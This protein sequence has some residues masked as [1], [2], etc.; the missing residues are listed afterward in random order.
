MPET[1]AAIIFRGG[2][3]RV[4]RINPKLKESNLPS[5]A[6]AREGNLSGCKHESALMG[7]RGRREGLRARARRGGSKG[8]ALSAQDSG[9]ARE[10]LGYKTREAVEGYF[11]EREKERLREFP[12]F[13][14]EEEVFRSGK[15]R[16]NCV[17]VGCGREWIFRG[18]IFFFSLGTLRFYYWERRMPE[19]E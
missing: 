2:V 10:I 15:V 5:N 11:P 18:G 14:K 1:A 4:A 6:R 19:E 9:R 7:R 16:S 3:G 13:R 12:F 8:K 17:M